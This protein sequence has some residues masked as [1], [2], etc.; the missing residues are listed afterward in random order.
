[1]QKELKIRVRE[2]GKMRGESREER[3]ERRTFQVNVKPSGFVL[4]KT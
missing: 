1:M 4:K 2:G 3:E